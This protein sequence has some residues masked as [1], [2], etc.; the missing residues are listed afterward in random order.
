MSKLP[1]EIQDFGRDAVKQVK[2]RA[3]A[4]P[5][6]RPIESVQA[7]MMHHLMVSTSLRFTF[8]SKPW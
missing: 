4:E 2:G 8:F 3:V 5:I 6:V 1:E 7:R